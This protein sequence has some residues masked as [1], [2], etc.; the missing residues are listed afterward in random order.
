[1]LASQ[2]QTLILQQVAQTGAARISELAEALQ[3]SEMTIRRD[4]DV[5][6]DQGLVDKVHGGATS[7]VGTSTVSEPPFKAKNLRHQVIKDSIA[8]LAAGLVSAGDSIALMGGSTVFAVA[9]HLVNIPRLTVVTNSLPVSDF[10]HREGRVDQTMI[11]AGGIRTPTDSFVGEIAIQVFESL[12]IDMVFMGTHG[13]DPVGGFSSPNLLESETNRAIRERAKSVVV[14]AD[15]TK[16]G[17]VGFSTFAGIEDADILV[18][19][20]G[21][22]AENLEYLQA[23]ISRVIVAPTPNL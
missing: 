22:D 9:R 17:E 23:R 1:M 7:A 19:D 3:V 14:L 8:T 15:H 4:I 6:V 2:R 18:T 16:W 5:L 12:N 20:S 10:F 13:M 11:T 21:L